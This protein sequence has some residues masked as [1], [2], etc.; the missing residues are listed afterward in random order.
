MTCTVAVV[1]G[2]HM[3]T[4][5]A[6]G[7]ADHSK[8]QPRI[9]VA[10]R[11]EH[12]LNV[13]SQPSIATTQDTASAVNEAQVV[14]LAVKPQSIKSVVEDHIDALREKLVVSVA[15]GVPM[16]LLEE[17]LGKETSI[18]HAMPN[19]PVALGVGMIGLTSNS[20]VSPE[21]K[22]LTEKLFAGT[23]ELVWLQDDRHVDVAT[24]VSG[25]GP[26][27]FFY[28]MEAMIRA[29][30]SIGLDRQTAKRFV[31]GTALGAA[32]M[33]S[34]SEHDPS[35]LR[36]QVASPGGTTERAL[37]TLDDNR[38][39]ESIVQAVQSAYARTAELTASL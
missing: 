19:L 13:Y 2:G 30:E 1:G 34:K 15:A 38:V 37:A 5:L 8:L 18:V 10:D 32:T 35:E 4:A 36:S 9:V 6:R 21:Q 7:F 14:V 17:W 24:A 27:Y 20:N 22:Q 28:A 25:S 23:G 33:A 12:K 26:A 3:G 39:Q 16:H 29:A 31:V 11:N